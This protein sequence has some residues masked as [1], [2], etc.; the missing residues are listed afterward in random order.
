MV[1]YESVKDDIRDIRNDIKILG[2]RIYNNEKN[3]SSSSAI[4]AQTT[5]SLNWAIDNL[6]NISEKIEKLNREL[7]IER[8]ENLKEVIKNQS[9]FIQKAKSFLISEKFILYVLIL[10]YMADQLS[11]SSYIDKLR[12]FIHG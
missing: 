8:Q 4:L 1:D 9:N 7:I 12:T 5:T 11:F 3:L 10:L 6:K 2:E